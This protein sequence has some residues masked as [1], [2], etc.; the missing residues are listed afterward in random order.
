MGSDHNREGGGS[1][2]V[3][4]GMAGSGFGSTGGSNSN[5]TNYSSA[6]MEDSTIHVVIEE[7]GNEC[8]SNDSRASGGSGIHS[9]NADAD[10]D[11]DLTISIT[12]TSNAFRVSILRHLSGSGEYYYCRPNTKYFR[13]R[14]N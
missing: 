14:C 10:A 7:N 2:A 12:V 9:L 1:S 11:D 3:A 8:S 13:S 5:I 4:G 6:V